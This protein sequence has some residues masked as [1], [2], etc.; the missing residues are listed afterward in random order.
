M[1]DKVQQ[2][3]EL[4]LQAMNYFNKHFTVDLRWD[5]NKGVSRWVFIFSIKMNMP[6]V[7]RGSGPP[8][9]VCA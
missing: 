1:K 8:M 4:L 7:S 2:I 5:C 9:C 6:D 3:C